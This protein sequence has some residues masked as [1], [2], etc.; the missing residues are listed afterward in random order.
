L[1]SPDSNI[2]GFFIDPQDS[3]NKDVVRYFGNK[4]LLD[5]ISDPTSLYSSSYSSLSS[6]RNGYAKSGNKKVLFN[7]LISLNKFYFDKSIFSVIK[8]VAPATDDQA[9]EDTPGPYSDGTLT[10]LSS[11]MNPITNIIFYDMYPVALSDLTF[12]TKSTDVEYIE[13]SATFAYKRYELQRL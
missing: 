2:F 5:S 1:I 12:D 13:C 9:V 3:K 6:L 7:E 11:S 8:N 10:I 4:G